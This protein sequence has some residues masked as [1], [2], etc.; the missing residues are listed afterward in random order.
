MCRRQQ[1]VS[2]CSSRS[3]Q[4]P[5]GVKLLVAAVGTVLPRD[6][7]QMLRE[8]EHYARDGEVFRRQ[9]ERSVVLLRVFQLADS[10]K[11]K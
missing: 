5:R 9:L 8:L 6:D 1:F 7:P 4:R 10:S 2:G 11:G 3:T